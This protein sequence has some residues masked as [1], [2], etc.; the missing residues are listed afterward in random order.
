M[1]TKSE[2]K[3]LRS[4]HQKKKRDE[5][6]VFV[7]EG[8][9]MINE[10]LVSHP[11]LIKL[12]AY[13]SGI[14][15][16]ISKEKALCNFSQIEMNSNEFEKIS[17]LKNPQGV[18]AVLEKPTNDFPDTETMGN[19]TLILDG[20]RDPGNLGTMIRLADWFG[21]GYIVCSP[22]TVDCFNPKVVQAT[23]GAI[24][25]VKIIYC[26]LP[27]ILADLKN[28]GYTVYGSLLSGENV[29]SKNHKLPAAIILG[30]EAQGISDSLLS[31][32]DEAI[33]IPNFSNSV[34]Q[35]ESL[36]VSVAAAI[37]CSE[38]R[39]RTMKIIQNEMK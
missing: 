15:H 39:R 35:S 13:T 10:A 1:I 22:D 17:M 31:F 4:L 11:Q 7:I 21:I 28:S 38:F 24:F 3:Y 37:L 27:D 34:Q 9:K 12:L 8:I 23:M 5:K 25:R 32:I 20:I 18:L 2:L 29:Y 6:N 16:E 19:L 33:L 36:N 26:K 14:K 30:N